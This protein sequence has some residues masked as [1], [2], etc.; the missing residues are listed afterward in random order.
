MKS[1][2]LVLGLLIAAAL[3]A[4]TEPPLRIGTITIH[5]LDVY[6]KDEARHGRLYQLADRLHI[7]TRESVIRKFLLFREGDVYSPERLAETERNL[8][9]MQFLKSALVVASSPHDGVV[10][11]VVTTQDSWSIAPETQAGS[12]GGKS[13]VGATLSETNLLGLGKDLELGWQN[14]VDRSRIGVTYNDPAFFAPYW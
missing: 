11:V 2:L 5:P 14:G 1:P 12:K 4:Q 13:T 9:A 6:S 10:D 7:E 3:N 8:R